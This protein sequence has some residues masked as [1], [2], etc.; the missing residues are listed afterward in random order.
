MYKYKVFISREATTLVKV[1]S[2]LVWFFVMNGSWRERSWTRRWDE[3][4]TDESSAKQSLP[5]HGFLLVL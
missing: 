5:A 2:Y 3:N 1:H 4:N